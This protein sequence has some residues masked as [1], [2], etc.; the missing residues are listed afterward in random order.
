[1]V[2][3][4][5]IKKTEGANSEKDGEMDHG[6]RNYIHNLGGFFFFFKL[7]RV[8]GCFPFSSAS[9]GSV[10]IAQR[11]FGRG[12]LMELLYIHSIVIFVVDLHFLFDGS[13]DRGAPSTRGLSGGRGESLKSRFVKPSVLGLRVRVLFWQLW[14]LLDVHTALIWIASC[15]RHRVPIISDLVTCVDLT[16]G[17][18]PCW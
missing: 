5:A 1:M 4:S 17:S 15:R 10:G 11:D 8:A 16:V 7:T 9:H 6:D 14:F 12:S 13:S 18:T 2:Q 3:V